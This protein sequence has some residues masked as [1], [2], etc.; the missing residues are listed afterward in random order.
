MT[1]KHPQEADTPANSET[2]EQ[3]FLIQ[4]IYLKDLSFEAPLGAHAF[5]VQL[6]PKVDQELVTET[7]KINDNQYEVQLKL[8]MTAKMD[9]KVVF[10]AEVHQAG[11]FRI[12]GLAREHLAR[13]LNIMC[14]QILFPYARETVDSV[15]VK[16]SF[17]ALMLPPV[18][19]EALFNQ[20]V[21]NNKDTPRH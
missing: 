8:T 4:R 18:N 21:E 7:R 13:V 16:G 20:A 19:F 14:P 9:D 3:Q 12:E 1:E 17:P 2:T 5:T 6:Q 15:L 10:L 11:L